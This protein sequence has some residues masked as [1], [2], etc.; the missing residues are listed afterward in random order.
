MYSIVIQLG[1][2]LCLPIYFRSRIGKFVATL[3][4]VLIACACTAG[5]A[6]LLTKVIGKHLESLVVMGWSLLIGG[7]LH[8]FLSGLFGAP[9]ARGPPPTER[10]DDKSAPPILRVGRLPDTST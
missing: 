2:I 5:P 7:I 9:R 6:F 8:R 3:P 4:Q 10:E 1:A